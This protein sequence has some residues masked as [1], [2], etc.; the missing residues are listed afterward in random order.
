M[1][2]P[3]NTLA[4]QFGHIA[5]EAG[6]LIM[7][8][9]RN[10]ARVSTKPDG[11]PVSDADSG[12]EQ[13]IRARLSALMPDVPIFAEETFDAA[14]AGDLPRRF[15]LVDPLDGTREFVAG[16]DDFVVNIALIEDERPVAGCVYAPAQDLLYV[17]GATAFMAEVRP[18]NI[19]PAVDYMRP[20][21]TVTY[22]ASGLRAV[23]SRSHLDPSSA[24][25][26]DRLSV[27][28]R[29][30]VGSALKFCMIAQGDAD[31]YPRLA[32]TMEW[33]S[34]AGQA[35]LTVAGGCVV[36]ED[37]KSLRYGKPGFRNS[38]FVAWGRTPPSP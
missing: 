24:A 6:R 8:V 10:G 20:I 3:R 23:V 30:P 12:A 34:A 28:A 38:G 14:Q 22:P 25:L 5:S 19:I 11:S 31:I 17:G 33:D 37:G 27:T 21:A 15:L 26:L 32:P 18:G 16:G 2:N 9:R 13:I 4:A 1:A 36:A 35:I 7:T 29:K